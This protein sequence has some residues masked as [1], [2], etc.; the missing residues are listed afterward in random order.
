[1]VIAFFDPRRT[2]GHRLSTDI[3]HG[4]DGFKKMELALGYLAMFV[5]LLATGPGRFS[6]DAVIACK[7][8]KRSADVAARG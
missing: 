7:W 6:L 3:A 8:G 5:A 2:V 4:D 1:M